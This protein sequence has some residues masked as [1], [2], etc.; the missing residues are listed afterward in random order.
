[1]VYDALFNEGR[2]ETSKRNAKRNSRFTPKNDRNLEIFA[3]RAKIQGF[4]SWGLRVKWIGDQIIF[5]FSSDFLLVSKKF[6][7]YLKAIK[8][9][10]RFLTVPQ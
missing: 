4:S 6:P 9:T 7:D 10:R 3:A 8:G 5:D 1:M 2:F